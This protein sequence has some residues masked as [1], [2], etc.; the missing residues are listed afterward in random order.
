MR[1]TSRLTSFPCSKAKIFIQSQKHYL[2]SS[3]CVSNDSLK[4]QVLH[5]SQSSHIKHIRVRRTFRNNFI[6]SSIN[7][8]T[9]LSKKPIKRQRIQG[10]A[11]QNFQV[12]LKQSLGHFKSFKFRHTLWLTWNSK[13]GLI[14]AQKSSG[15]EKWKEKV[16]ILFKPMRRMLKNSFPKLV[17]QNRMD[18]SKM[19]LPR[20]KLQNTRNHR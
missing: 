15:A 12:I 20:L 6:Q 14:D 10:F 19:D 17:N 11:T 3:F 16:R 4:L 1:F 8:E 5:S 2:N 13:N 18:G 7:F 9:F